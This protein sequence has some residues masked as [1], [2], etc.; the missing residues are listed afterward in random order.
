MEFLN[1][2][3]I[4]LT[5]TQKLALVLA[6]HGDDVT[7]ARLCLELGVHSA[8]VTKEL[9]QI[10]GLGLLVKD[11]AG[12]WASYRM[13]KGADAADS[14]QLP[15]MA[16]S[17]HRFWEGH[18]LTKLTKTRSHTTAPT[19]GVGGDDPGVRRRT[20]NTGVAAAPSS[21]LGRQSA[22]DH[23]AGQRVQQILDPPAVQGSASPEMQTEF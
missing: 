2:F 11:G 20:T 1:S 19:L 6:R 10:R 18:A 4:M 9:R 13:P 22:D 12:R 5:D 23:T 17:S 8:D 15:L 3:G 16:D 21:R 7:N 14:S